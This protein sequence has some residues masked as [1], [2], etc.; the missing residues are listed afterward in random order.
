MKAFNSS[1]NYASALA[2]CLVLGGDL[3]QPMNDLESQT[4]STV[5]TNFTTSTLGNYWIG[6][7]VLFENKHLNIFSITVTC[8]PSV[9]RKLLKNGFH[10]LLS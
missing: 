6:K 1:V 9:N 3:A 2:N 7:L 8:F 10:L 5:L 4:L